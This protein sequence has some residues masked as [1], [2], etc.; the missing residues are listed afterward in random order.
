MLK[1]GSA[2]GMGCIFGL[3]NDRESNSLCIMSI[4]AL[5]LE[6]RKRFF[7]EYSKRNTLL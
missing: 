7:A 5:K 6:W 3:T 2:T 1:K 4:N